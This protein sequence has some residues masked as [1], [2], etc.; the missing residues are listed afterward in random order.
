M[1]SRRRRSVARNTRVIEKRESIGRLRPALPIAAAVA[2]AIALYL[3]VERLAGVPLVCGPFGGCDVVQAS[4]YAEVGG[5]PVAVLG[6]IGSAGILAA[7]VGWWRLR[8]PRFLALVYVTALA[9]VAVVVYLTGLE[10]FVIH[11]VCTWCAAY[12]ATTLVVALVAGLS[13]RRI[14]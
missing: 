14:R 8:D 13:L 12:A 7:A 11:A 3:V 2:F 9:A 1:S 10:L 5:V 6:A 4:R